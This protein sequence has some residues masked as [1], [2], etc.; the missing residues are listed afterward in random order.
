M[1]QNKSSFEVEDKE[2]QPVPWIDFFSKPYMNFRKP[3]LALP[4]KAPHQYIAG[5]LFLISVFLL[6]GGVY[7]LAEAPIPVGY[8]ARGYTPIYPSL[9]DQ[10][11]IESITTMVFIGVGAIGFFL[12]KFPTEKDRET[13]MRSA[14]FILS[15]AS[16]LIVIG[17]FAAYSMFQMKLY[18]SI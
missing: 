9:N 1:S 16:V 12:I 5:I 11:L 15:I 8:T 17:V 7:D 2:T 10:F 14:S 18:G 6:A 3:R 13:D 4:H